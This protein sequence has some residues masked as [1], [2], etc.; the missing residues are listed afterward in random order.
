[1]CV[2]K[3][4]P[5]TTARVP[6]DIHH[7]GNIIDEAKSTKFLC[8]HIVGYP[9]LLR[10]C[11]PVD[12]SVM[13]YYVQDTASKASSSQ[14]CGRIG[15]TSHILK[16]CHRDILRV[17]KSRWKVGISFILLVI[18]GSQISLMVWW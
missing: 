9:W 15:H 17:H 5:K 14:A 16:A 6:L 13:S 3:F 2:I 12:H 18:Q 11:G 1:M 10:L 4:T 7:K 8:M